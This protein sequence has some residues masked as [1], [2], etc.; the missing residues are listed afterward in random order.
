MLVHVLNTQLNVQ[1]EN[2]VFKYNTK[3]DLDINIYKHFDIMNTTLTTNWYYF[4]P[5]NTMKITLRFLYIK[6]WN[7]NMYSPILNAIN[8]VHTTYSDM[9]NFVTF[10]STFGATSNQVYK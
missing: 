5:E 3:H 7:F 4:F 6:Y 9:N 1:L 8:N 2:W 10:K